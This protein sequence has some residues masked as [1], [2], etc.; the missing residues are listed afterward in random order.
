MTSVRTTVGAEQEYFLI[1]REMFEKRPDLIYTGRTL[2]GARPPKGQQLDDHYAS[3]IKPAVLSFMKEVD[4]ELW[5]LGVPAKTEHNEA[6][7]SQ[8]E[9]APIFSTT[10]IATDHN[11]LIM[12][13]MQKVR[14]STIWS[15]CS[16]RSPLILSTAAA[17][18]TTGPCRRTRASTCSSPGKRPT[19]TPS[20]SFSSA[21]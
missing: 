2:F 21:P 18:T 3:S 10:N 8:H 19:K 6:A 15:V 9:L 4:E 13:I 12:D 7:P 5:K 20:S 11:Q 1:S 17:S 14:A 16:T